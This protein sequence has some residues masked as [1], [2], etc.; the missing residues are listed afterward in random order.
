M[1]IADLL[2]AL[3]PAK[4]MRLY[5]MLR[6]RRSM[7]NRDPSRWVPLLLQSIE[8]ASSFDIQK[9]LRQTSEEITLIEIDLLRSTFRRRTQPVT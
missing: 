1:F 2:I 7:L 4:S 9:L 6:L 5:N 3:S 8:I